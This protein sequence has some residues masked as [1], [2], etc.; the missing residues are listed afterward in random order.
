MYPV[1]LAP[2]A[3]VRD[4]DPFVPHALALCEC[5]ARGWNERRD[6]SRWP[7]MDM[8]S[9]PY[10]SVDGQLGSWHTGNPCRRYHICVAAPPCGSLHGCVACSVAGIPCRTPR[11]HAASRPCA[12][13]CGC[14]DCRLPRIFCRI[15][16]R[17]DPCQLFGGV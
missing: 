10:A 11:T 4:P 2:P 12:S 9:L 6:D 15:C 7:N 8:V 14:A 1:A 17:C 3:D 5:A 16:R 13:S